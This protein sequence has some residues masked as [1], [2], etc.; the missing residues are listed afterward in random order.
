MAPLFA[1]MG[2]LAIVAVAVVAVPP[3][4]GLVVW[5]PDD[6]R[7]YDCVGDDAVRNCSMG[8]R[9]YQVQFVI[10]ARGH[11]L[12]SLEVFTANKAPADVTAETL[13]TV[14]ARLFTLNPN[15][16]AVSAG[17][18]DEMVTDRRW[19][20]MSRSYRIKRMTFESGTALNMTLYVHLADVF[21]VRV[22][23]PKAV[24]SVRIRMHASADD[25]VPA[26]S[27]MAVGSASVVHIVVTLL[28]VLAGLAGL[29]TALIRRARSRNLSQG[30]VALDDIGTVAVAT[31]S[32]KRP[33]LARVIPMGAFF[34]DGGRRVRAVVVGV[35]NPARNEIVSVGIVHVTSNATKISA[36][37]RERIITDPLP[38][39]KC[40][41]SH[42]PDVWL[43]A[44][45][46]W[47]VLADGLSTVHDSGCGT[48]AV[49]PWLELASP[50]FD[51][52][53]SGRQAAPEGVTTTSDLL[54]ADQ[55]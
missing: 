25:P 40:R 46:V 38:E 14:R 2:L 20:R 13:N 49:L 44:T 34:S 43:D 41:S 48:D 52:V 30:H 32:T 22:M 35:C 24:H 28:G 21:L 47:T 23:L 26:G 15:L 27:D 36:M 31:V 45:Q 53:A 39:Y 51:G 4:A 42:T 7:A 17:E 16:T 50:R 19:D 33:V 55:C 37:C 6:G 29:T 12:E 54:K 3:A 5:S 8:S 11:V 10:D 18:W 1:D 9:A